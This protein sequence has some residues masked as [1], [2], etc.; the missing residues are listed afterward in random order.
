MKYLS[1]FYL[2]LLLA[3]P[4][5]AEEHAAKEEAPAEGEAAAPA[6]QGPN[7]VAM[8]PFILPVIGD[9][10]PEQ[11]V[12]L[13]ISLEVENQEAADSV[14]SKLPRLNDAYLET[15]YGAL[16]TRSINRGSLVDITRIKQRLQAP[17]ERVL[18]KDAVK[19]IL[20]QA[21]A[22]RRL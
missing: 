2:L 16:D 8:Q 7:Y 13:M 19:N 15:L 14:K 9:K 20:V 17:T 4:A 22:Q 18:G 5:L 12:T 1:V 6:P 21:V 11:L 3:S 10:G